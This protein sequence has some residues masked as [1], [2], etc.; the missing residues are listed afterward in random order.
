MS[1]DPAGQPLRILFCNVHREELN[2]DALDAYLMQSRPQVIL[3][4]DYGLPDSTPILANSSWHKYRIGEIFIASEYPIVHVHDMHLERITGDDDKDLPRRFGTAAS[5][6]LQMPAGIVHVI[7]LHLTSPHGGL[8]VLVK[9]PHK[10]I[11]RLETNSIRRENE[12][13]QIT[14]WLATQSGP[15]VVAGD[16]NTPAESPIFRNYWS[17]YPDAFLVAGFGLG[18]T[19][20]SPFSE[21]RID[22]LL[23]GPGVTCTNYQVGPPCGTPHRPVLAD[24]IVH[25]GTK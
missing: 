22:H 1:Q 21:L 5:F 11:H 6:D 19:H 20:L 17:K 4:Q 3:L 7:N 13:R 23:T 2:R 8:R 14:D 16:F 12:S 10:G 24:L 18:F 25:P 9:S 15:F